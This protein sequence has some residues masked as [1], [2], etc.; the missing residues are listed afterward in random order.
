MSLEIFTNSALETRA[1]GRRL[2]KMSLPGDWIGLTGELGAGKT[3]LVQGLA[4]GAG[5]DE[6]VAV[7]SPTYVIYQSYP[8]RLPVHHLDLYRL[9]SSDELAEIG[10]DELVYGDGVCVVEWFERIAKA[11]PGSGLTV[12]LEIV[13]D[14]SRRLY[15]EG[16]DS[17]GMVLVSKLKEEL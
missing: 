3:C 8:G 17:R 12:S 1:L 5:V 4:L 16:E 9:M 14:T 15:I 13:D 10:Y 11:R 7:T 6:R 2:G